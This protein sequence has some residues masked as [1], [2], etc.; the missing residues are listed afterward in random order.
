MEIH[1]EE[2]TMTQS[3]S[4]R[5]TNSRISRRTL[6]GG[7]AAAAS[8]AVIVGARSTTFA[9]PMMNL[10][11]GPIMLEFWGGEPEESG[12]G[13][14]V[15]AFNESQPDIQAK[16][17]R[18]VND[19]TGNTQLD[20]ALQ[21]GTPI[22]VYQSYG[23]PR[24]SQRIAAGAALDLT[25][26]ID[27]D[28]EIK[29]WTASEQLFTYEDTYFSLPT[30]IDPYVTIANQRLLEEA[31]VTLPESWTTDEFREMAQSLSGEFAYGTYAPQDTTVQ[32]L[33][34]NRWFK[35][36]GAESNFDDPAFRE[37]LELHRGMID[38]GSAFPWT[39]VLAR[40]LRV[41]QQNIFLTEQCGLWISSS[42]VL[43]Y[44]ND[45]EEFPHDFITT[46]GPVPVPVGVE[47]PWTAGTLGNEIMIN[48]TTQNPDAAWEFLRFRL[49]EGA[50]TYLKSGKQPAFPGTAID[51]VVAGI[52]GPDRDTLYD[53]AAYR[54]AISQPDMRIPTDTIT[55]AS[56]QIDQI[57]QQLSDQYLIGEIDID[58]C[59]TDMKQQ[60]DEAITQA[61]Q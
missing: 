42:F 20:T 30:V 55:I 35:G 57:R 58:T 10:L 39:D 22:D 3:R 28:Q 44:V 36:E 25:E 53:V 1:M 17:T 32:A 9:A 47:D 26:Y 51:D 2:S 13:D 37:S 29:D 8:G 16:Y 14:L 46:F 56:A 50:Y 38:E 43:R 41:Y 31:G 61:S 54:T 45:L 18:Y 59:L 12:P 23:I 5:I 52:L 34:P 48:P 15:A 49:V 19:D 24:S 33:G 4:T 11:Q 60:A 6:V 7:A 21:G 27:A 40:N